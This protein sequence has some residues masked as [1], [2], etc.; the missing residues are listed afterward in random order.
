MAEKDRFNYIAMGKEIRWR[1]EHMNLTQKELA[2]SLGLSVAFIGHIERGS[3]KASLWTLTLL[4]EKLEV[5]ADLLLGLH[6]RNG[7]GAATIRRI[8]DE[9]I[10]AIEEKANTLVSAEESDKNSTP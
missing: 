3:R 6:R 1:R 2:E 10:Q 5:S 9:L 4:C 7:V 8:S